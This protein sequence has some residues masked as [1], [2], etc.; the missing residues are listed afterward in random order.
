MSTLTTTPKGRP[1]GPLS[2]SSCAQQSADSL[3]CIE[4]NYADKSPCAPF[5]NA[6]KACKKAAY[7]EARAQRIRVANGGCAREPR[8]AVRSPQQMSA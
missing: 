7:E 6:Y 1:V 3:K 2:S 5:F 8:G 4:E